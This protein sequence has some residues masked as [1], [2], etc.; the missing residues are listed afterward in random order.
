MA[1]DLR[2]LLPAARRE[3]TAATSAET[4]A[5]AKAVREASL[6]PVEEVLR[7]LGSNPAGLAENEIP[8]RLERYGANEISHYKAPGWYVLLWHAFRNPFNILLLILA[9]ISLVTGDTP[10]MIIISVMVAISIFLRFFQE[11]RST[12]A[13]EKLK[14]MVKVTAAIVR[15]DATGQSRETEMPIEGIVPGDVVHLSAGDMTPAD[16]RL[17]TSK[18][19]FLSQAA[20]TGEALPVEKHASLPGSSGGPLESPNMC[21]LGTNVI[22]GTATAVV[23]ATGGDTYLGAVAK[24]VAGQRTL[25]SFEKGIRGISFLLIRFTIVMALLVFLI[26]GLTKHEWSEAFLFAVSV[27]VGL[28]P[29]MLPMIVSGTLALGAV[30]M[31]HKKVIVKRINSI[32]NIGA[33]DILCTDKTGTLT[34]GKVILERYCDVVRE[35]EEQVLRLAYLNSY[36]QTGLK[37]LMDRAVLEHREIPIHGA[38]KIDEIP[39]DFSRRIMSIVVDTDGKR[40][41]I[42]K[43]APEA[44]LAR[45][46]RFELDGEL[47]D[48]EELFLPELRDE[49]DKLSAEGF[50]C[51]ALGYKDVEPTRDTYSKDDECNL[52]LKGY[53]AFLDPP[54]DTAAQ[55]IA[56]LGVNGVHIKVLTGDNDIV[57]RKICRDV[58][59]PA[60]R[61]VLGGEIDEKRDDVALLPVLESASVFARLTPAHKERVIRVLR[62]AGHVVGFLGDGINDAP[63]LRAADVGISVDNAVDIAKESADLILLEKSLLVL[64]DAVMEGR[65]V[66]GNIVKYIKMGT[67]SNFGNMFSLLGA[68]MLLPF[69]PMLPIQILTQNLLYDFS[70]LAIP[71]DRVDEE[72]MRK[73]RQWKIGD[74]ARFMVVIGPISSIFDYTTFALMFFLFHANTVEPAKQGLF[75]AGWFV[76]GLLSQTLIVHMIRTRK[77]PF[78]QSRATPVMTLATLIVMAMGIAI[79]FTPVG[80][81]LRFQPLP[82]AYFLWLGGTLISYAVLTQI[83]KTWF[84]RKW[85]YN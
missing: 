70:Q 32:Q 85:G 80:A 50:R 27:A 75:Q 84:A 78:I 30:A 13:A 21:F 73:P 48:I 45:C 52:I 11:L 37:N 51:L 66:F 31:S 7:K 64:D 36:F 83:V 81:A 54:K 60:E 39:F 18:D 24:S 8:E 6:A 5:R 40:L 1:F 35:E 41:L 55:A 46:S 62:N 23:V 12:V 58:G 61:V 10:S 63:A 25:T 20:L 72:Y 15:R 28:T 9:I 3:A 42:A 53:I 33:I 69:L 82:G 4:E 77:I 47:L 56:A 43:G 34:Q 57:S 17:I 49:L 44:I 29:E 68:S 71:F 16:L 59:L 76:E 74:I 14:A 38:K 79:P 19:L 26:N 65:R 2:K 67:S 22:S